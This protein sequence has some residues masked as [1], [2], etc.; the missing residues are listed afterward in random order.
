[1]NNPKTAQVPGAITHYS[2][3]DLSSQH[4]TT[5]N[6]MEFNVAKIMELVPK[7][8]I[9]IDMTTFTRLAPM[10]IPTFGNADIHN[11]AF[12][13]PMRTIMK[14][15]NEF[16]SDTSYVNSDGQIYVPSVPMVHNNSILDF[17][18]S[19]AG[20]TA[21]DFSD[22]PNAVY[23][24][25]L[26]SD[27]G[28]SSYRTFTPFGKWAYKLL[29]SLGYGIIF[30]YRAQGFEHSALPLLALLRVYYDWYYPSAYVDDDR[31]LS[32]RKFFE[33]EFV[34][35]I[36]FADAMTGQDLEEIF[37]VL[38]RV[39]YDS[40]Y[41]VSAW[42]NP[43]APND[44][45]FTTI[46]LNDTTGVNGVGHPSTASISSFSSSN[47]TPYFEGNANV[48]QFA[49]DALKA[50][51]DYMKRHQLAGARTLDRYLSR[52]GVK[53]PDANLNRSV[54]IGSKDS[55]IQFGDVT[56]TS[57][58]SDIDG[59]QLGAYAGKGIGLNQSE[60]FVN[61]STDEFGYLIIVS[62]I[63]PKTS[64]YQG[65]DRMTFRLNAL[66]FYSPEF[67]ALG[68]Q[69]L[70]T[71]ELY[72]P[73]RSFGRENS[74]GSIDAN[75]AVFGFVP[76]FADYKRGYDQLTGDYTLGSKNVGQE[77]WTLMRDVSQYF[78]GSDT[79][80]ENVVHS[81]E[82]VEGN[83]ALQYNRIFYVTDN[84]EDKFNVIHKFDIMT[85]FP[86]KA[87]YDSYE[88]KEEDRAQKVTI[89]INGV[90]QN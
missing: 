58:T 83:D 54:L 35:G 52:W 60:G 23:D 48:T 4:I 76:R 17:L 88:F 49:L 62:T 80:Y 34:S 5:A 2:D 59:A 43:V 27:T 90:K 21:V 6:F 3:L 1:M 56:S 18:T 89:D 12:F 11:R 38:Y 68:V 30:D 61:F 26:Y 10:P 28:S 40:D 86:G 75:N 47:G 32:L 39:S 82:F 20:S 9:N 87:M 64:Y 33:K 55:K 84:V 15:W 72:V 36:L 63:V 22:N 19:N 77:G 25:C 65:T 79:Q 14:G 44:G 16:I 50:L 74:V 71:R 7:Q 29:R 85:R 81:Q 57:D 66:D 45:A 73:I 70:A 31:S 78:A 37:S 69:A 46:G 42:D 51:N 24:F 41:F 13:V 8:S 53:L 67:D